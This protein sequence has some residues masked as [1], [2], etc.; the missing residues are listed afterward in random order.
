MDEHEHEQDRGGHDH[1]HG[2]QDH[3]HDHEHEHD[4]GHDHTLIT[5]RLPAGRWR[6]DPEG[7]EV[8][9]K[10]RTLFGLIP[11]NG[12]F[13]RFR[14]ELDAQPDGSVSGELVVETASVSS[15]IARRDARLRS[16]DFFG[17]DQH[18]QLIFVLDQVTPSGED[19]LDVTGELR[20]RDVTI[21]L[22]FTIYAIAHD[23]HL[24]IE[25]RADIDHEAAGLGWVRPAT[26]SAKARA[27]IALTLT[28]ADLTITRAD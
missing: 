16:D 13:G 3:D 8:L 6:V 4:H 11:V 27:D 2:G 19:H 7:S 12:E 21:P 22:A 5:D 18:P 9:F 10:A 23:D 24:H 26:V 1:D 28:R 20:I 17:V 25:G 14:G 15:G